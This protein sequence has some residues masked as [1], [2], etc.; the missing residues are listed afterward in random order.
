MAHPNDAITEGASGT[1][2][3]DVNDEVEDFYIR[4]SEQSGKKEQ[5]QAQ[6]GQRCTHNE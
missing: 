6:L 3:A 4:G 5:I 2:I 1:D